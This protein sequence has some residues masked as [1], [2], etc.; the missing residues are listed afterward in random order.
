MTTDFTLS[1]AMQ[2]G[3]TAAVQ[4]LEGFVP[5]R[6]LYINASTTVDLEQDITG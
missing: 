1:T 3:E 5:P 6:R 2:K 4:A